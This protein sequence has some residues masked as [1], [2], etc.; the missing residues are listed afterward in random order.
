MFRHGVALVLITAVSAPHY[1]LAQPPVSSPEVGG[2]I[3]H[4][5]YAMRLCT[6]DPKSNVGVF[7]IILPQDA[8]GKKGRQVWNRGSHFEEKKDTDDPTLPSARAQKNRPD[9]AEP[10]DL[11]FHLSGFPEKGPVVV[12]VVAP[13]NR[14]Y[15]F[16]VDKGAHIYGVGQVD[17]S[18]NG[19]CQVEGR[20]PTKASTSQRS[21]TSFVIDR[22]QFPLNTCEDFNIVVEDA[23]GGETSHRGVRYIDPK[24]HNDGSPLAPCD[25]EP[26]K[27][28]N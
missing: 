22:E 1:V 13:K 8:G 3:D 7:W 28:G 27:Q 4:P 18:K 9:R 17:P 12:R 2:A 6:S 24:V 5:N 15:R 16:Y 26:T 19:F 10:F 20:Y 11:F 14:N 21:V 23:V 25:I